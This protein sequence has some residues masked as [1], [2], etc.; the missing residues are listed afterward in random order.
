MRTTADR[1]RVYRRC[2]CRDTHHRQLEAHCPRL[3]TDSHH[4]TWTF[5]IDVPAPHQRLTA[6][7]RGGHTAL[8]RCLAMLSNALGDAVRQHRLAHNPASPP[9]LRRPSAP[10]RRIWTADEAVRF[11]KHCD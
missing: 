11:L 10:E 5:A 7:R 8:Y 9:A 3:P 2:G 4:G 6:V 1:G